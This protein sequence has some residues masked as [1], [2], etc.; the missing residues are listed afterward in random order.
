MM[1]IAEGEGWEMKE[2]VW[3]LYCGKESNLPVY[4][5][6]PLYFARCL[7]AFLTNLLLRLLFSL[8][9]HAFVLLPLHFLS[10]LFERVQPPV[11][12]ACFRG[13]DIDYCLRLLFVAWNI[14]SS[15]R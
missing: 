15:L 11:F 10:Q 7:R 3:L 6:Y 5:S 1:G 2:A 9:P 14:G 12:R 13:V 8:S 4:R